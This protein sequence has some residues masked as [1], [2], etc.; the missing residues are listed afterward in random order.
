MWKKA[1]APREGEDVRLTFHIYTTS[2]GEINGGR[3][4]EDVLLS[5][6]ATAEH[7]KRAWRISV[8]IVDQSSV[9]N[10]EGQWHVVGDWSGVCGEH[11]MARM[12]RLCH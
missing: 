5:K 12:D 2:S 7:A 4:S 10:V 1:Q 8:V 9:M 11:E 3:V 6:L